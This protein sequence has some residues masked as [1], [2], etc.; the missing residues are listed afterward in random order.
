MDEL[1]N[2]LVS[3][4][5]SINI[6]ADAVADGMYYGTA[7]RY[8]VVQ[9]MISPTFW[10]NDSPLVDRYSFY[11][12]VYIPIKEQYRA[13]VAALRRKLEELGMNEVNYQGQD[14][15]TE[16]DKRCVMFNGS[17]DIYREEE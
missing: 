8:V 2:K 15:D 14:Q 9:I 7:E 6:P 12:D 17:Y 11:F 3:A 1:F 10:G 16:A 5:A 4:A 13:W